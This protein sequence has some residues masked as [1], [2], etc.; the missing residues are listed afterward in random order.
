MVI[1]YNLVTFYIR[2]ELF[3]MS[4]QLSTLTQDSLFVFIRDINE[5]ISEVASTRLALFQKQAEQTSMSD[6]KQA[7]KDCAANHKDDD[8]IKTRL[9]ECRQLFGAIRHCELDI[10]GLGYHVAVKSARD[11][12]NAKGIKFDGSPIKSAEEKQQAKDNLL[13][14]KAAKDVSDNFDFNQANAMEVFANAVIDRKAE[15]EQEAL[16]DSLAKALEKIEKHGS[17]IISEFGT[18]YALVLADWLKNK[19]EA[20]Q[21]AETVIAVAA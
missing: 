19:V 4:K 6:F 13:S 10:K 9:S 3:I 15:L 20:E 2:E 1:C 17:K 11:A 12:L 8:S 14:R 5:D 21:S 18:N 7:A 16:E